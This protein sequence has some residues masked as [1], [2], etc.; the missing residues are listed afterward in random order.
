MS[1]QD[2]PNIIKVTGTVKEFNGRTFLDRNVLDDLWHYA[3]LIIEDEKGELLKFERVTTN[4]KI[5][6]EIVIGNSCTLYFRRIRSWNRSVFHLVASESDDR[7]LNCFSLY[8]TANRIAHT[9]MMVKA[10][11]GAYIFGLLMFLIPARFTIGIGNVF[12]LA[13]IPPIA[14]L[15]MNHLSGP[16]RIRKDSIALHKELEQ[17]R[18]GAKFD[19]RQLKTV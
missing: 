16:G 14:F 5:D 4:E 18:I 11:P 3:Y 17:S 2:N 1:I 7:G 9:A 8:Q 19:G 12:W 10:V 15:V 13:L 6:P